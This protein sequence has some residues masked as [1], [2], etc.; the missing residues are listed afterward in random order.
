MCSF[1]L[2]VPKGRQGDGQEHDEGGAEKRRDPVDLEG[3]KAAEAEDA[4]AESEQLLQ[5]GAVPSILIRKLSEI[6]MVE[7]GQ[8]REESLGGAA[9]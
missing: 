2:N 6:E 3:D 1:Q 4:A 7:P 9:E 8:D 5:G